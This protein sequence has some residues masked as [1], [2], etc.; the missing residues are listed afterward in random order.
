MYS[1]TCSSILVRLF[2]PTVVATWAD[3]GAQAQGLEAVPVALTEEVMEAGEVETQSGR[4]GRL[5][6]PSIWDP[7]EVVAVPGGRWEARGVA[8]YVLTC[9]AR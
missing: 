6:C 1:E 5:W 2:P 9:L 8:Q 7:V 4:T 3:M